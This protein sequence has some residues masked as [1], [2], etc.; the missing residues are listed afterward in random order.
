M[1]WFGYGRVGRNRE[2]D[3][4]EPEWSRPI[5]HRIVDFFRG[6]YKNC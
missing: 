4:V 2:C 5:P 6:L 1:S 3:R